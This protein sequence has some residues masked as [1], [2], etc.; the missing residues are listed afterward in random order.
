MDIME[1][2]DSSEA[3]PDLCSAVMD[4][5]YDCRSGFSRTFHSYLFFVVELIGPC[6]ACDVLGLCEIHNFTDW[7]LPLNGGGDVGLLQRP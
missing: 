6:L 5:F 1:L 4:R 3:G 7:W 2:R